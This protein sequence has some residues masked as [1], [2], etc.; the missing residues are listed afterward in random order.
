MHLVILLPRLR[1]G[2]VLPEPVEMLADDPADLLV[3]RGPM[4]GVR[5]LSAGR[6]RHA[7]QRRHP[8][9]LFLISKQ[10]GP[11]S[12]IVKELVEHRV[13]GVRLGNPSV[14]LPHVQNRVDDLAEHPVEGGGRIVA[15]GRAPQLLDHA[16]PR[17][18]PPCSDIGLLSPRP[19]R[20]NP[21]S[22]PTR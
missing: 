12:Q 16:I 8:E 17:A 15:P 22:E 4:P 14:S 7:R 6:A 1:C 11:G 19:A 3:A 9:C 21:L 5:W 13:E 18:G 2:Q 20:M 10:P